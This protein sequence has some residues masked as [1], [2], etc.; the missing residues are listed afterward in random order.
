MPKHRAA[1]WMFVCPE[2]SL[3]HEELGHLLMDDEIYCLVCHHEE[4]RNV[5]LTR[6]VRPVPQGRV[7]PSGPA[8]PRRRSAA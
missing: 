6:W 8:A 3:G 5:R 4:G 1:I 2:C 7:V